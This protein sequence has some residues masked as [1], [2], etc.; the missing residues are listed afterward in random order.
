[1]VNSIPDGIYTIELPF[2]QGAITDTGEGRYLNL[3]PHGSLGPDADKISAVY[4]AE[5]GG[6]ALQFEKSKKYLT[7]VEALRMNTKLVAGDKPRHF[8]ITRHDYQEDMFVISV[9]EDKQYHVGLALE[10]IVPPWIA[11]SNFPEKQAWAFK[12]VY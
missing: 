3:L 9:V 8:Q 2:G 12:S 1:M 6:Y 5:R 11:L 7:W 4:K 10:R